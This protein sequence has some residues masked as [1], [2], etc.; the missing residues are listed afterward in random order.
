MYEYKGVRSNNLTVETVEMVGNKVRIRSNI[1]AV[2]EVSEEDADFTGWQY[3]EVVYS[4]DEYMQLLSTENA[5]LSQL[6]AD[7]SELVLMGGM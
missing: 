7:V 3:D 5:Q 4:K 2:N 6:V 1:I